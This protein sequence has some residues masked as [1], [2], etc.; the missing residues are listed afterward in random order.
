MSLGKDLKKTRRDRNAWKQSNW[1][2]LF[3]FVTPVWLYCKCNNALVVLMFVENMKPR[4]QFFSMI[5]SWHPVCYVA[6]GSQSSSLIVSFIAVCLLVKWNISR[7][8]CGRGGCTISRVLALDVKIPDAA[9]EITVLRLEATSLL[10]Q[11][12]SVWVWRSP[13]MCVV[14]LLAVIPLLREAEND[15]CVTETKQLCLWPQWAM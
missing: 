15:H 11:N 6:F 5:T 13:G 12:K 1:H 2:L 3:Q 14:C 8:F 4:Y 9:N 10:S 7:F